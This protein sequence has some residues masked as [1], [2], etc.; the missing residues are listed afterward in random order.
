MI[1]L[2]DKTIRAVFTDIDGVWT[3][4]G[5]YYNNKG[6]AF[7][8][9]NTSD[10]AGVLF[11][12]KLEIPLVVITGEESNAVKKRMEKLGVELLFSGVGD[13]LKAAWEFCKKQN[14]DLAEEAAFIG[15][16]LNDINLLNAAAHSSVPA[17]APDYV[18]KY[19]NIVMSR[20]GGDG[21]FREYVEY[22]IRQN[23]DLDEFIKDLIK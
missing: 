4:G 13:K 10:S 1:K 12:K 20:N 18:K 3:D 6:E 5:M 8:K 15:N 14:I 16:D 23:M 22:L 9:F 11:L 21:V 19:T 17:D 2:D 7:K